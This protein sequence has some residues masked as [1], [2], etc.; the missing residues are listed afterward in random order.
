MK[1]VITY[2]DF[3]KLDIRVGTIKSAEPVPESRKLLRLVVDFGEFERQILAGIGK[4]YDFNTLIGKQ[5]VF[6]VNLE[7]RALAGLESQGMLLA[8]GSLEEGPAMLQTD[9][10]MPAGN[11]I[12]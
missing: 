1:P 12:K 7:P 4:A 11:A 2:V 3:E 5:G 10:P 8:A 9:R 6:L